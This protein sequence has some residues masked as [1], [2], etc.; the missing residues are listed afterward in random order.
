MARDGTT[1]P[2]EGRLPPRPRG[3][4]YAAAMTAARAAEVIAALYLAHLAVRGL[5]A[6]RFASRDRASQP[7]PIDAGDRVI[8]QPILSGDPDLEPALAANLAGNP[9]ARF[10][11]LV[12]DD[13]PLGR[14]IADRLASSAP[15]GRVEV[16]V[17]PPPA[18]GENP[19]LA[20]LER[21]L[22]RVEDAATAVVLD[23]DTVIDAAELD[24]LAAALAHSDLATGLPTFVSAR[25]VYER[26]VG[27]FV[28]GNALL[29]YLPA[30]AVGAQRTLNG[31]IYATPART[32]RA[33]GGF[34]AVVSSLTDDYAMAKLYRAH[35]R[36]LRQ[37]PAFV[38]VG[39]TIRDAAHCGRV[40]RRW[41]IFANR[42]L[43]ENLDVKTLA[44]VA[45][46]S[47]LAVAGP[48]TWIRGG[49]LAVA[50]WLGCLATKAALNRVL[51]ARFAWLPRGLPA[52]AAAMLFEMLVDL[53]LP[54]L[55]LS[56]LVRP[57]RL[58]WR[59]RR[60]DLAGDS[61]RYE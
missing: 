44:L 53:L 4:C 14:E 51:L 52:N 16:L 54:L 31:M 28:N 61:I 6:W 57:H 27:G 33:V 34:V 50:L 18:N 23:D 60:I 15:G 17:G 40:M 22:A 25:T 42:Y 7:Q 10:V 56:A 47:L 9:R 35:G 29:T 21:G 46:P 24:R 1:R 45:L 2:R 19:K 55:Y 58:S 37:V 48:L 39:M 12:D 59:S 20:K 5:L 30:A 26:F 8:L 43:R 11:W 3:S 13:D 32:L 41:L 38:R 36:T 49:G